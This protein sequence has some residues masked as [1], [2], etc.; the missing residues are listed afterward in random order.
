MNTVSIMLS[1]AHARTDELQ[2]AFH[3]MVGIGE[4]PWPCSS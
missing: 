2:R 1:G 3:H 4:E